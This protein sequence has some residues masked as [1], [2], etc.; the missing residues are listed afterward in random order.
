M[1]SACSTNGEKR[2]ESQK[3]RDHGEDKDVSG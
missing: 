3:E 1:G 2:L